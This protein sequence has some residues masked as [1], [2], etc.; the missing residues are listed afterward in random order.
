LLW[1]IDGLTDEQIC[2]PLTGS[3]VSLL[4]LIKHSA[5]VERGWFQI[6]FAGLDVET[7]WSPEDTEADWRIEPGETVQSIVS[8]YRSECDTSRAIVK[9]SN[10]E[11]LSSATN[12]NERCSLGWVLTHMVEEVARHC[13]H[14]DILREKIVGSTGH[15]R[16]S[17][18]VSTNGDH[19]PEPPLTAAPVEMLGGFLDFLRATLLWKLEGLSDE[20]TRRVLTPSGVSL[21][22]LVKHSAYVERF[23]FQIQFAGL[24]VPNGWSQDDPDADWRIE[25]TD[26]VQ[27]LMALYESETAKS[28]EIVREASWDDV[29]Q[30]S[31]SKSQGKTLGWVLTHM[32]EEIARHCGHADILREMIDGA[33]GE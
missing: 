3:G 33:T 5:Y 4:G 6:K 23:W 21:I 10:W 28:R 15:S 17:M 14:A 31:R 26:T 8:L 2:R 22:S 13:G 29:C 20:E 12:G 1:K 19:R 27:G 30:G 18:S 32:V 25:P 11:E 7:I 9:R 24:D 16:G